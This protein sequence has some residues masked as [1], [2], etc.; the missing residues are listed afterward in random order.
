VAGEKLTVRDAHGTD[1]VVEIS[2]EGV[3]V[4]GVQLRTEYF[5]D[6]RLRISSRQEPAGEEAGAGPATAYVAA[7]GDTLWVFLDGGVFVF[8][9]ERA[10]GRRKRSAAAAGS[11]TAPM[12]ATVRRIE[13][14]PGQV[15]RRG[16]IL[17]VLE[18]MKM[19]LPVRAPADGTIATLHCREGELVPAGHDLLELEP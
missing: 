9:L 10:A 3:A 17:I 5:D 15:V 12:P 6:R 19:E 14:Q 16:D 11:L 7:A 13:V 18:A 8:Q 4:N 1:Y 2:A